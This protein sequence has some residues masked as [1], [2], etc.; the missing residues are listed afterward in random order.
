MFLM[1]F[2][3]WIIF[4]GRLTVEVALLGAVMTVAV[5][6]FSYK[7]LGYSLRTERI[8]FRR[9]PLIFSYYLLLLKEIAL[10]NLEVMK[11]LLNKEESI[12]PCLYT[13][14]GKPRSL[15]GKAALADSITLTPGTITVSVEGDQY[16]VHCLDKHLMD[17]LENSVF[18]Q[19]ILAIEEVGFHD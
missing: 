4:N 9:L 2:L 11:M 19:R 10:A 18:E 7:F 13:F 3:L 15:W 8:F 1:L 5:F 6:L 14:T 17:G 16:T 12:R